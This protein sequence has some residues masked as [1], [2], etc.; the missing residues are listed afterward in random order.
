MA[1][2]TNVSQSQPEAFPAAAEE[3]RSGLGDKVGNLVQEVK[4]TWQSA[5]AAVSDRVESVKATVERTVQAVPGAVHDTTAALGRA[6][7]LPAHVRRHPW[8][9]MGGALLLG[10]VVGQLV[11]R[12][13][14]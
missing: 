4:D 1:E 7:D 13:R 8:L 2:E 12:W 14:R 11:G 9:V 5:T 6:F 10:V 3:A